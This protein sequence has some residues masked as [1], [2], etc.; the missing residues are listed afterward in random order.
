MPPHK[1]RKQRE[2]VMDKDDEER[3]E[4]LPQSDENR[5]K[6]RKSKVWYR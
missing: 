6:E 1:Q 3:V 4:A 5:R 2:F